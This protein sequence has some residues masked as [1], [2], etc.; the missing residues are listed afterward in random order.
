[1]GINLTEAGIE[2]EGEN[3]TTA[4]LPTIKVQEV[5]KTTTTF[6]PP[7]PQKHTLSSFNLASK[8]GANSMGGFNSAGATSEL[9]LK[10]LIN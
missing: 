1:M 10:K 2:F 5:H 6:L 8:L 7:L 4:L 3:G 9:A